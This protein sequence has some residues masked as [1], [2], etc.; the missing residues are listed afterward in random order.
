MRALLVEAAHAWVEEFQAS[1]ETVLKSVH[2]SD[3][4]KEWLE[5]NT[6]GQYY[7]FYEAIPGG[8]QVCLMFSEDIDEMLLKLSHFFVEE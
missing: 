1:P 3:E 5:E 6:T 2:F 4:L 8:Y 7:P